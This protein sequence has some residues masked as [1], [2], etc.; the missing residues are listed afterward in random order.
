MFHHLDKEWDSWTTLGRTKDKACPDW[1]DGPEGAQGLS[2]G[3]RQARL[4]L[5]PNAECAP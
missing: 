4:S 3:V 1:R 5:I 2:I